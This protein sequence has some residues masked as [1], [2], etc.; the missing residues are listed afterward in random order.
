[1]ITF[2]LVANHDE[3]MQLIRIHRRHLP[4]GLSTDW[5]DN[6]YIKQK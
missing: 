1:M 6:K 4:I 5:Y 3:I 2:I